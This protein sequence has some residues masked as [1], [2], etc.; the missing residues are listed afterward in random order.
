M[1]E[2]IIA[3]LG[4]SCALNIGLVLYIVYLYKKPKPKKNLDI[5]AQEIIASLMA[6]PAIFKIEVIEKDS[7]IQWRPTR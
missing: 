3:S 2:T 7:L 4:F 6:G 5:D 1:I